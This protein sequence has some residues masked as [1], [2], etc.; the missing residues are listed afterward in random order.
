MKLR[1]HVAEADQAAL[2]LARGAG[3]ETDVG[4]IVSA[5][6]ELLLARGA[7]IETAGNGNRGHGGGLLLA[8]GAGIETSTLITLP[9]SSCCSSQEEQVLKPEV[10]DGVVLTKVSCS[11]QEEQVLKRSTC[12]RLT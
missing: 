8:R 2:L 5:S 4:E 11:S 9:F 1:A 12:R 10:V 3:I 7:G 6:A